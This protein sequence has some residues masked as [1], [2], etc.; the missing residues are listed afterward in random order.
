MARSDLL[1][2]FHAAAAISHNWLRTETIYQNYLFARRKSHKAMSSAESG[3]ES[4]IMTLRTLFLVKLWW[5]ELEI[6]SKNEEPLRISLISSWT[7]NYKSFNKSQTNNFRRWWQ[8]KCEVV[9]LEAIRFVFSYELTI[10]NWCL[11]IVEA[12]EIERQLRKMKFSSWI[13]FFR[14]FKD[15]VFKFED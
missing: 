7:I 11:K 2:Q 3:V 6:E 13:W 8:S 14:N 9:K 12:L 4:R 15:F 1:R 10:L 5:A